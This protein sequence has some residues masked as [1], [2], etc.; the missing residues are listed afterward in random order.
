MHVGGIGAMTAAAL[1]DAPVPDA[2][3]QTCGL[4]RRFGNLIAVDH[5]DLTIAR[6]VIFGLLG[7]NG[8]GKSTTI[9]ML[10]TLLPPSDGTARVAGYDIVE[11]PTQVRRHIGYVPPT[12]VGRRSPD[13]IR[14]PSACSSA[15][16]RTATRAKPAHIWRARRH[17]TRG[18]S[19]PTRRDVLRRHGATAGA[20]PSPAPPAG[21]AHSRRANYWARSDRPAV[22]VGPAPR[23]STRR[24]ENRSAHYPRHGGSGRPVRRARAH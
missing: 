13:G 23:G 20:C 15:L 11:E 7:P 3:V 4:T 19:T 8:A 6:G 22:G 1:A 24:D 17:G 18:R 12:P 21:R 9:K 2:A 10:T 16:C 14:K 5:L